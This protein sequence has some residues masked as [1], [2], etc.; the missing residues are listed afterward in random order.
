M[1]ADDLPA[2][3]R[4]EICG[5]TLPTAWWCLRRIMGSAVQGEPCDYSIEGQSRLEAILGPEV[6]ALS[7]C[8]R[9]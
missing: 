8:G 3:V 9:D 1:A 5:E 6:T 2:P 4:C 7:D